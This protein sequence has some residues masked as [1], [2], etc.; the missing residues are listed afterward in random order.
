[1][2]WVRNDPTLVDNG[3]KYTL[4]V[5]GLSLNDFCSIILHDPDGSLESLIYILVDKNLLY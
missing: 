3:W 5:Q 1:M 4:V 2:H